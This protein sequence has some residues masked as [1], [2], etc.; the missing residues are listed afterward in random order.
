MFGTNHMIYWHNIAWPICAT[1]CTDLTLNLYTKRANRETVH[2]NIY[3]KKNHSEN[4]HITQPFFRNIMNL[5]SN[6]EIV[7]E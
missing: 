6:V 2:I 3:S 4:A 5:Y 1:Q 7:V